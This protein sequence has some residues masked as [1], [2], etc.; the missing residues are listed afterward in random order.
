MHQ[1]LAVRGTTDGDDAFVSA[2]RGNVWTRAV[3]GVDL[4]VRRN[5][6]T[7]ASPRL[8]SPVDTSNCDHRVRPANGASVRRRNRLASDAALSA[9][10][11]LTATV[12]D[13]CVPRRAMTQFAS[14]RSQLLHPLLLELL[15][16]GAQRLRRLRRSASRA[17]AR[18]RA[19]TRRSRSA[20]S[21]AP[22]V[23]RSGART[24]PACA[25]SHAR[26]QIALRARRG[27]QPVRRR[28]RCRGCARARLR[29]RVADPLVD[30][31]PVDLRPRPRVAIERARPPV[32]H[33]L[34]RVGRH[35]GRALCE[36]RVEHG[37]PPR[38]TT[39]SKYSASPRP[40]MYSARS[41]GVEALRIEPAQALAGVGQI[42]GRAA[43]AEPLEI[44]ARGDQVGAVGR[45][46]SRARL[47]GRADGR[48]ELALV[49]ERRAPA[50][51][52][53]R[54]LRATRRAAH[55]TQHAGANSRDRTR[56]HPMVAQAELATTEDRAAHTS[57]CRDGSTFGTMPADGRTDGSFRAPSTPISRRDIDPDA[58]K[59]LYRL[60]QFDHIAYLVGGSV[61]DLLL[62]RRP[63]DFDIGTS[64]HPVSGQEAVPELLDH[65]PPVPPGA[66]EVR[67]EG[68]R[69]RDVPPAGRARR[70]GRAGRRAGAGSDDA[71]RRAPDP[72]RQHVRHAGRG[73]VPPR[74]H[75]QRAVLRHR[76][77]LDHRLRRRPRRSARRHRALDRRSRGAASRGSGADAARRSRWPRG[78]TSRSIRRSSTPSARIATRSRKARRRGCSRSTTRFCAPARRR[79]RS[80]ALAEVG[81]LE[82]ISAEL[83][84]GA[85]DPL[86]R[87]L[88]ALD[89]YR[90]PVRVDARDADERDP[91]RA[92]CSCRS[93]SRSRRCT[94]TA[95]TPRERA[96]PRLGDAA[97]RAARR[98]TAAADARDCSGGCAISAPARARS[99]RSRTAA[100]FATR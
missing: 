50:R 34:A 46:G 99:A 65:R 53:R 60:R 22:L 51:A 15:P 55:S 94:A 8:P 39:P 74:L 76:D 2:A 30:R 77:V 63:K 89:A 25:A 19:C 14:H 68:D 31:L 6:G 47:L 29:I 26:L 11:A 100:S 66:R 90:A 1:R 43:V 83:H 82:P 67:P 3:H 64:A 87:S 42:V 57:C 45:A 32:Q 5:H 78:S 71:G 23:G 61:R 93:A 38:R 13:D 92:V 12:A 48:V 10:D 16:L 36:H 56:C 88:A 81:L 7:A 18:S 41:R 84:R 28:C 95:E 73:R 44:R 27:R 72:P 24:Q 96:G 59:V 33:A 4:S 37:R 58:L 70:G 52:D 21:A 79:R 98:R 80:A 91:A 86:W 20:R 54:P 69:G 17:P 62:G 40:T 75:D 49:V 97:A 35:A 85:D 9:C